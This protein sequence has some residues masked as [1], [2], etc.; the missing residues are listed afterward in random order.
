MN[1]LRNK[2][3]KLSV[4]TTLL[5][6]ISSQVQADDW[7]GFRGPQGNPVSSGQLPLE[8]DVKKGVNIGWK[9]DIPGRGV[10][11]P[12]VVGNRVFVT[13][14]GGVTQQRL[15]VLCF[16]VTSGK[17]LWR[18]DFWAT[19][20]TFSHPTSANAA[21]TPV[22]DG[23]LL[24]AFYSSND[25][26][27]LDL[28][29]NLKWFRGLARDYPKAGNDVGMAASPVVAG[30]V[31]IVQIENQG[32]SFACAV[33]KNSG[34]EVW[35]KKRDPRANWSSPTTYTHASGA[36]TVILQSA[37]GLAAFDADTGANVWDLGLSCGTVSSPLV[38]NNTLYVT[39][40]GITKLNLNTSSGKPEVIWAVNKLNANGASPVVLEDNFYTLAGAIAKGANSNTGEILWQLRLKGRFWATPILTDKH[41]YF[42]NQDGLVQIVELE[43]TGES[44]TANIVSVIDMGASILGTPA[45]A[46]NALFI[47]SDNYL[48]KVTNTT[49]S[50]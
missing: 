12:I 48:W 8:W 4:V 33:D 49:N 43:G 10:S 35:R 42:I 28:E 50:E 2:R 15:Y 30:N 39:S 18:R 6:T 26:I 9:S 47:R 40:G 21:P 19:G 29:G 23:K 14:S 1:I 7:S 27:C 32:D 25:L 17:Q 36:P 20:R 16:D 45:A 41:L 13:A 46:G 3:L 37:S 22:S 31:V 5:L 11:G 44:Q 38:V 24:F 34:L